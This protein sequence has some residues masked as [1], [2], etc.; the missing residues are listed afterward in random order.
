[1]CAFREVLECG[2]VGCHTG[3]HSESLRK[4]T[5]SMQITNW[6]DKRLPNVNGPTMNENLFDGQI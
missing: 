1:M 2:V 4:R 3:G 5:R 6:M